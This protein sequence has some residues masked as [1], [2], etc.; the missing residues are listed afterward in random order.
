MAIICDYCE[1]E[2]DSA[3]TVTKYDEEGKEKGLELLCGLCY[4]EWLQSIK[5]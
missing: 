3:H 1:Q 2:S 5:G 4:A